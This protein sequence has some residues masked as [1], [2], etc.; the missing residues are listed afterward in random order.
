MKIMDMRNRPLAL[1]LARETLDACEYG[2]DRMPGDNEARDAWLDRLG[3]MRRLDVINGRPS[4]DDERT[5]LRA[6]YAA[7]TPSR[8]RM[9][10]WLDGR[11]LTGHRMDAMPIGWINEIAKHHGIDMDPPKGDSDDDLLPSWA[12]PAPW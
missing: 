8:D 10:A 7:A 6:W 12:N 9:R 5:D 4:T 1:T 3:A 2:T 11:L